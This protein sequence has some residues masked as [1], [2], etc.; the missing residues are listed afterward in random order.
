MDRHAVAAQA[1]YREALQQ[2]R[3]FVGRASAP[4]RAVRPR[5]LRELPLVGLEV[6]PRDIPG[7]LAGQQ[8]DTVLARPLAQ[9][10]FAV[11]LPSRDVA[12]LGKR[13]GVA[14]V[15]QDLQRA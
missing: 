9:P 8:R 12:A 13:S 15:V 1:A 2:G 7:M 10:R 6:L 5:V 4:L 11:R 14:R 3:S